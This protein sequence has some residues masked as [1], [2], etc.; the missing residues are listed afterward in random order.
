[1]EKW[2]IQNL[3]RGEKDQPSAGGVGRE[4][5]FGPVRPSKAP[6]PGAREALNGVIRLQT[7]NKCPQSRP[8][9]LGGPPGPSISEGFSLTR[10]FMPGVL[11][12]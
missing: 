5:D 3:P 1:M 11:C 8:R 10:S 12:A 7:A 2:E 9:V 4:G 6:P